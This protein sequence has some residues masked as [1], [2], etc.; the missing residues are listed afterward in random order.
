M[1]G[2]TEESVSGWTIDTAREYLNERIDA[3]REMLNE[4]Y[5]TQTKATDAA[6]VAQ[7]T[8]MKTA[9]DAADKA[10]QAALSAAEK[11]TNKANEAADKRF[12]ATNEFRE[13]QRDMIA[14]FMS[15]VEFV[16]QHQALEAIVSQL[17]ADI[18]A[19][20][21]SVVPRNEIESWHA[22]TLDKINDNNKSI[23]ERVTS[24]ELRLSSR[25]DLSKGE[26]SGA[27]TH[28]TESRLDLSSLLQVAAILISIA[29]VVALV[30]LH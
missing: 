3:L 23:T 11:A 8:A 1:S 20:T 29:T 7:Q 9:F 26:S 6:F 17:R 27:A 14:G 16:A 25:L 15:R 2:E 30:L 4:R 19:A 13:Q 18:I 21:A 28:R 24:L 12:A 22:T 10:V 5:A